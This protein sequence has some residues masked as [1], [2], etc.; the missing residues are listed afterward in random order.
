[1]NLNDRQRQKSKAVQLELALGDRGEAPNVQRSAE[2][3]VANHE[4]ESLGRDHLMELVVMNSNVKTALKRV[5][6]NKGSPG[7]DGMKVK[8]LESH[9]AEHWETIRQQ[10]VEGTYQPKPVK[11][12]EIPKPE[13]GVRQLGIPTVVDRFIQQAILQVLQPRFDP[14][15][16]N[17]SYG[18]RPE[19]S[20]H[21]AIRVT[22]AHIQ[23]GRRWVVDIDLEKFFDRVNHDMLMGRLSQRIADKAMLR[24]IRRYLEAGLMANG[25]VMERWEGTPQG[26]PLSPLLANVYLDEVD[27]ELEKR[28]HTFV[29]YADDCNVYVR[30]E[31]AATRVMEALKKTYGKLRLRVNKKKSR[32]ARVWETK[33]LG[34]SFWVAKGGIIKGRVATKALKA[35]KGRVRELTSR[36]GGKSLDEVA[37]NLTVY[38]RGWKE[39]FQLAET[40][41]I[42]QELDKWIRHRIRMIQIKQWKTGPTAYKNLRARGFGH[43]AAAMAADFQHRWWK[44]A[45]T[46]MHIVMPITYFNKLGIPRLAG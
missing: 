35:M 24:T 37:K 29:R 42:F 32:I 14:T 44:S 33:F 13:G 4:H 7:I 10:L 43:D 41:G 11:G 45:T 20:A 30:S 26:G 34:Y 22:R 9:L 46:A 6:K 39:Y 18:F 19:R 5:K 27:R 16:S 25:V 38:L 36:N 2:L 23:S 40:P 15:F 3:S 17:H 21:D 12:V 28:G 1:M 8:E 31:R